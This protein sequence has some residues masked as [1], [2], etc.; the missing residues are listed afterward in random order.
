LP[1]Y[2]NHHRLE[3][4]VVRMAVMVMMVMVEVI[5]PGKPAMITMIKISDDAPNLP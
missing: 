1:T 2:E 3:K 4:I 5:K